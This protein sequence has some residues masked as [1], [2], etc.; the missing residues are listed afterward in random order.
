[1]KTNVARIS[2]HMGYMLLSIIF[3]FTLSSCKKDFLNPE[4]PGAPKVENT[5]K[6]TGVTPGFKDV[7]FGLG[8]QYDNGDHPG[9]AINKNNQIVEVHKSQTLGDVWF[10]TGTYSAGAITWTDSKKYDSGQTPSVAMN[11]NNT[12][13][14]VHKTQSP[15]VDGIFY[16]VGYHN[17]TTVEWGDSHKYDNGTE[18]D[19]AMNNNNVVV[20]VHKS[21]G[22]FGLF[23]HVGIVNPDTKTIEWGSSHKYDGGGQH[24][25][26][27]INNN[28]QAVEVHQAPTSGHIWY[29]V[30]T[31]NV[32]N[33]TIDWGDS[34]DYQT[35]S[36]PSVALLDNGYVIEGHRSE[37][38]K[39]NLW[40]MVGE[41]N[42]N[43]KDIKWYRSSEFFDNG[44]NVSVA[45][46]DQVAIQVHAAQ[47]TVGI[48]A[49]ASLI[50]DRGNWMYNTMGDIGQKEL[51]DIVLP[52]AHDAGMYNS[53]LGQ[54]QDKN[55]YEQLKNGMRFFDLRPD[56]NLHIYHGPIG[57]PSVDEILNHVKQYMDEGHHELVM[58]KFSHFKD[59][60]NDVYSELVN[61]IKD[62]L[63]PY[64]YVNNDDKRLADRTMQEL[65]GDGGKVVILMDGGFPESVPYDGIYVYRD[66]YSSSCSEGDIV[67]YDKYSNTTDFDRMRG[68]QLN[69]YYNFD[70]EAHDGSEA[71]MFLMSWTLTPV[72]DV[73]KYSR[74]ANSRLAKEMKTVLP[75]THGKVPN[76][77]YVDYG[78]LS[79]ATDAAIFM[80][81]RF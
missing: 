6:N 55:I 64:L 73:A 62:K 51:K 70:G 47:N 59:F 46:N 3:V 35:G 41:I 45:A 27:A 77:L 71:D 16:H 10:R 48:W 15:F 30:G 34:H 11:D 65:V 32:D 44:K 60:N 19:V 79:R 56:G 29:R 72:T 2:K 22:N 68:D 25:A 39:D 28:N 31:I 69:K 53:S 13:V 58:L 50:T 1:M 12:V 81:N 57:G 38:V 17:G 21:Q 61:R 14:E 76:I 18:P 26:I 37:G 42:I 78:Q 36:D 67:L 33:K 20:E 9:V 80:N 52:G 24:A 49:S 43:S 75:N 63:G 54:T 66:N 4:N 7:Q 23:Y 8:T 74:P 5:Y 40:S